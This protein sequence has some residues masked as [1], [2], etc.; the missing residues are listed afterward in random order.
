MKSLVSDATGDNDCYAWQDTKLV[1][2]IKDSA[3][4]F[5]KKW[6]PY[7]IVKEI[8]ADENFQIRI[9]CLDKEIPEEY[10]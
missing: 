8:E 2:S 4:L 10:S 6:T 5:G 7:D 9:L 3:P 1:D